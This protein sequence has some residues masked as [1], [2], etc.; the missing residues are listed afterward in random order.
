MK[1]N[2][3]GFT[4]MELL[5][6]IVIMAIIFAVAVPSI[7]SSIERSKNKQLNAK[8]EVIEAAGEIYIS[9]HKRETEVSIATLYCDKLLT[10]DEIRNPFNDKDSLCGFVYLDGN[11]YKWKDTSDLKENC[12]FLND[13]FVR[14]CD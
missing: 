6:V 4:L 11:E 7:S 2:R 10:N 9:N 14:E 3:K 1:L 12:V 8:I 5:A 13:S